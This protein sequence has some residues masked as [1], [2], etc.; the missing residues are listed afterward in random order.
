MPEFKVTSAAVLTNLCKCIGAE[1]D[2]DLNK[3]GMELSANPPSTPVIPGA[4]MRKILPFLVLFGVKILQIDVLQEH[5][6][7]ITVQTVCLLSAC[8]AY[9]SMFCYIHLSSKSRDLCPVGR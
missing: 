3:S 5:K 7:I 2:G 4:K 9:C 1:V 8:G 6:C